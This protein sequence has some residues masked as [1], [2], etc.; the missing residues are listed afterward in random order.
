MEDEAAALTLRL[1]ELQA[2]LRSG[3]GTPQPDAEETVCVLCLDAPK[4]HIITPCGHQCVCGACA[5]MLKRV[6]SPTCPICREPI[7]ATFKVFLA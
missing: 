3:S 2:G 6:K 5:E 1:Q 7:A 4:D